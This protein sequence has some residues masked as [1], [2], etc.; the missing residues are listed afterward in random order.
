LFT[1]LNNPK[2]LSL[3]VAV[4]R[5]LGELGE[6]GDRA[7][8]GL[9][10]NS[11]DFWAANELLNLQSAWGHVELAAWTRANLR[12]SMRGEVQSYLELALDY[13]NVGFW[14][15]AV[16]VLERLAEQ[17]GAV[18]ATHPMLHYYLGF[19]R[20]KQG[21][22]TNARAHYE[23]AASLSSDYCF[24]FRLE[25]ID[26]LRAAMRANP[27]D[28]RAPYYLGNLLFEKQ[29][30]AARKSWERARELDETFALV[31]RNL[32]LA[33]DRT[34]HDR[35]KAIASYEK[36]IAL[37]PNDQRLFYELDVLY[38]AARVDPEKRLALLEKHHSVLHDNNVS[39][40]L[41]REVLLL[42]L[43]GRYGDALDVIGDSHFRQW[44]GVSKAYG[45][46]V[47][48]HLLRGL[49][50]F[51]AGRFREA[52][53]DYEAALEFPKNIHV[54]EPYSG[55]RHGEVWYMIGTAHAALGEPEKARECFEKAVE[56]RQ[57]A[58]LSEAWFYRGLA[59]ARVGRRAEAR[60]IFDAMVALGEER[61]RG[62]ATDFFAKFGERET[63]E[64][65]LAAAHYLLGLGRLGR[66]ETEAAR[67]AFTRAVELNRNHLWAGRKLSELEVR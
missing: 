11:L 2:A 22:S 62:S 47:D 59:L 24:P 48:A 56:H 36:A 54:A 25:S 39:D 40:A 46:F 51:G 9:E 58:E 10:A 15:E 38:D 19:F 7:A 4:L 66:E 35:G 43:V 52:L 65:R 13:G 45:T 61:L 26:V 8:F 14:T 42:A 63:Q 49:D 67:E 30:E 64:D 6:A 23:H 31:H 17:E 50:H 21:E 29:P 16:D 5:R 28:A 18:G 27:S 53:A 57:R 37:D 60:R 33:Y 1:N 41:A 44:E 55:G 3:K 32:G 20:E 34:E 12:E